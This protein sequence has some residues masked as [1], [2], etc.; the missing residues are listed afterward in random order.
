MRFGIGIKLQ[1]E[2]F[3]ILQA[4]RLSR[5]TRGSLDMCLEKNSPTP[6]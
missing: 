3:T 5:A 1:T 4:A 2:G 6:K